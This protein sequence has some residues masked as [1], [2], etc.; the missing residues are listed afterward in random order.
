M[1]AAAPP[2][3]AGLFPVLPLLPCPPP[4]AVSVVLPP[5]SLCA[6]VLFSDSD[7]GREKVRVSTS[8]VGAGSDAPAGE[9]TSLG[10]SFTLG[11]RRMR[12]ERR[13]TCGVSGEKGGRRHREGLELS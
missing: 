8:Q 1:A 11:L 4:E 3:L 7:V 6:G 10:A 9:R 13:G 2:L 5:E 12:N